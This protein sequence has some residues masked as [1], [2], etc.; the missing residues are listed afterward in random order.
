VFEAIWN[1]QTPG[2]RF[3]RIRVMRTNG[4]PIG[5]LESSIRNILRAADMMGG[6]YPL[7]LL[8][9][10]LSPRSQRIGDYAAGTVVVLERG[11]SLPVGPPTGPARPQVPDIEIHISTMDSSDYRLIRSFLDR[12]QG[13][14]RAHREQIARTLAHRLMMQWKIPPRADLS[15]E[16]FLEAV[17]EVYERS[18]RAI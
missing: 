9:M 6:L 1:G 2:K 8:V 7:G 11:K 14:D 18:R 15:Y 10:F 16:D 13:M 17:A 12:R 3:Q 4:E 5:W